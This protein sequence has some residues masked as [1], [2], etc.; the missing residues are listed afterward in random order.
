MQGMAARFIPEA[1]QAAF[2][3]LPGALIWQLERR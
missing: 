1:T 2:A 3:G